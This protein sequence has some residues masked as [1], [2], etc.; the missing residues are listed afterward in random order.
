[1][2]GRILSKPEFE[3]LY[4]QVGDFIGMM[5]ERCINELTKGCY[6][7]DIDK[8]F[9]VIVE[10]L[11]DM[12][13]PPSKN[14][15]TMEFNYL[16]AVRE[17]YEEYLRKTNLIYFVSSCLPDF[18]LNWHNLEWFNM[19]QM[20]PRLCVL[21]ARDHSKSYSF[22]FAHILWRMYRYQRATDLITPPRDIQ[23][24][25]EGMLITNEYKLAK[26][27]LKKV[28]KEVEVNPS[29]QCIFPGKN[30]E[31]WANESLTGKN[32]AEIT[33]S[34][35]RTSNR[36]PHPTYIILDD[37]LD[38]SALYSKEARSKF[39]EVF[40]G[41]IMSMII[42][43]G[44]VYVVGTPFTKDDLYAEIKKDPSFKCFEYP[45]IFPDGKIL[46][47]DRYDFNSLLQKRTSLGNL[48]FSREIL[49]RP[50]DDSVSIFPWDILERT[51]IGMQQHVVVKNR[52]SY[53]VKMKKIS[54]G[55]DLAL[56]AEA[57][58]DFFV[59][60]VLGCDSLDCFHVMAVER[61]KGIR[62]AQ[63]IAL[64]QRLNA[65]FEPDSIVI[66]CNGYQ[67]VLADLCREA[68][69]NNII[70]FQTTGFNKKDYMEGL[71]SLAV[72][73]ENGIIK[74]PRGNEESIAITNT[75]CTEFNSIVFDTDKGKLE[76]AGD[77]DDTCMSLFFALKGLKHI[78]ENISVSMIDTEIVNP[79]LRGEVIF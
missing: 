38:R 48:V 8:I 71:P 77:H 51:F 26:R 27:L 37:F 19:I 14:V 30:V 36:G 76:S 54:I 13:Y 64:L 3:A 40:W 2:K 68:G 17:S 43:G 6:G 47:E 52:A 73:F 74:M 46:W 31:G 63:Q 16:P 29:L 61:H 50:I 65:D 44:G 24:S 66:E 23:L 21:A 70:E 62:H 41:E 12:I 20:Y 45:A 57:N 34:S 18:E 49:V 4:G 59:A 5:D 32:G 60:T 11:G 75:V 9:D 55:V 72:M 56:S 78:N 69:M 33:L 1:M 25:K 28:K 79:L 53:G 10:E 42:P 22:S 15:N 67:K 35:Y 58:A 7:N 39:S